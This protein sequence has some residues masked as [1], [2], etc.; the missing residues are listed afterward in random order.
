MLIKN[1]IID[2]ME[3]LYDECI[4][5]F[6]YDKGQVLFEEI[7]EIITVYTWREG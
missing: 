2:G 3:K 7:A 6:G 4:I 1:A 5:A